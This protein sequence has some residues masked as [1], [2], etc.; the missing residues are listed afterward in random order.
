MKAV[1]LLSGGVDSTVCLAQAIE[2]EIDCYALCFDYYQNHRI[3]IQAAKKIADHY[4]I[5]LTCIRIDP[6]LFAPNPLLTGERVPKNRSLKEISDSTA[7]TFVPGRNTLFLAS[8]TSY[9]ESIGASEIYIGVG[10]VDE[11]PYPDC[12]L[13]FIQAFQQVIF[14]GNKK[15]TPLIQA[16]LIGLN[17]QEIIEEGMR[18]NAPLEKT[19][20]CYDPYN[21]MPCG[22]C[23]ACLIRDRAFAFAREIDVH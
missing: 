17:K 7:P 14:A 6:A 12:T 21:Q 13:E 15:M 22:K 9:A 10:A 8:A 5:P 18:L 4:G 11:V 3:E 19:H 23:D 16:P 1:I 2:K 20:S